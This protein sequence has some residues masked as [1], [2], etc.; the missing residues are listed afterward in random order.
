MNSQDTSSGRWQPKSNTNVFDD[1]S[2]VSVKKIWVAGKLS[3]EK[4]IRNSELSDIPNVLKLT[5]DAVLLRG[6]KTLIL[7]RDRLEFPYIGTPKEVEFNF[8]IEF[9]LSFVGVPGVTISF[10]A[11]SQGCVI[12]VQEICCDYFAISLRSSTKLIT[13][14]SVAW[15]AVGFATFS[16]CS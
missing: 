5:N 3:K 11:P 10:G 14:V 15:K 6:T 9:P 4:G 1:T 16:D 13:K 7:N 12:A 8:L 2:E